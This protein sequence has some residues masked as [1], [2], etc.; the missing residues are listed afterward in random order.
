MFAHPHN[1]D[2]KNATKDR[3]HASTDTLAYITQNRCN[4]NSDDFDQPDKDPD[5][6]DLDCHIVVVDKGCLWEVE[7]G[8]RL[9]AMT[10]FHNNPKLPD[11]KSLFALLEDEDFFK[12]DGENYYAAAEAAV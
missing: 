5:P 10:D 6:E 12:V 3:L 4:G 1:S 2:S 9:A 11:L 8:S 7:Y